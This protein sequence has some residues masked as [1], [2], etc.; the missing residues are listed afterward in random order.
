MCVGCD[1]NVL[2]DT[3]P[4]INIYCCVGVSGPTGC[5]VADG[6]VRA[7]AGLIVREDGG[8]VGVATH[9][10]EWTCGLS[11][12]TRLLCPIVS[13]YESHVVLHHWHLIPHH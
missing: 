8:K 2:N 11:G 1:F 12:V 3:K 13:L 9:A 10:G 6:G 4:P 7:G 5:V